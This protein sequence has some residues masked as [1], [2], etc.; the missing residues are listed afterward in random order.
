MAFIYEFATEK[1]GEEIAELLEETEFKGEISLAYCRRPN[2]VISL[3]KE[4][5]KSAFVIAKEDGKIIGAGGCVIKNG[6]AYLTGMRAKKRVNIA[7]SYELLCDFCKENNA[8]LTYTTILSDNVTV[9][10]MLE[11]KR[12]N[13]PDYLRYGE[14]SVHIIRK[15]LKIKDNN[16]LDF[17]DGFY[18]LKNSENEKI[19][20]GKALEQWDYK[21]YVVKHYGKKLK[22]AKKFF[23]W[24]PNENEVL[25]FFTLSE[26]YSK[27]KESLE[28][29]LRHISNINLQGNFF[30]YGG[31]NVNCP[32]KS[33]EYKSIVYIVDWN[34]EITD[35]GKVK[36]DFEIADL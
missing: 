36:F 35:I 15:K 32:V 14:C 21:Q 24:I 6:I 26:V 8:K 20:Q 1:D 5:E 3:Q 31:M 29:F 34:K 17:E 30:L 11:R 19:A 25:K 16:H 10:Q 9:Q 2:A 18:V 4:G 23:K 33:V 28:S 27:N 12:K 13:M 7:K 22:L